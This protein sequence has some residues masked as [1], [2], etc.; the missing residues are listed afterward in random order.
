[1]H[2]HH[3]SKMKEV[4]KQA[5]RNAPFR[6]QTEVV[7]TNEEILNTFKCV[8]NHFDIQRMLQQ[9]GVTI[10]LVLKP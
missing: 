7:A 2:Q 10:N 1:M 5:I 3:I 8:M 6:G 4:L 9:K